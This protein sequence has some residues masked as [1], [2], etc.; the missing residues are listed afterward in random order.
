MLLTVYET[1]KRLTLTE[2]TLRKWI[3]DGK[4]PVVKLGRAVRIREEVIE[5]IIEEGRLPGGKMA[6]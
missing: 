1:A 2:S 5:K 6:K 3:F 4:I